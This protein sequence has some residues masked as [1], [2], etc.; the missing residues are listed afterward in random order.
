[1]FQY[2]TLSTLSIVSAVLLST[3]GI[4]Q[5]G[6]YSSK[7]HGGSGAIA[8]AYSKSY[9]KLSSPYGRLHVDNFANITTKNYKGKIIKAEANAGNNIFLM[10]GG[11]KCSGK[12]GPSTNLKSWSGAKTKIYA[13]GKKVFGKAQAV[14]YVQL[15]SKGNLLFDYESNSYAISNFT[16]LGVYVDAATYQKL[17][18]QARGLVRLQ[19]GNLAKTSVT[20]K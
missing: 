3:M 8:K 20:I 16:P 15:H 19:N 18:L 2:K 12:C 5:A 7:K 10:V 11:K 14:N 4:A 6:G 1:M 17:N 13:K 9:A